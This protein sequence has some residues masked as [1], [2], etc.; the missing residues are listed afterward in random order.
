MGIKWK[1]IMD[2]ECCDRCP[3]SQ[4]AY[5]QAVG[6]VMVDYQLNRLVA[7]LT[8]KPTSMNGLMNIIQPY[9]VMTKQKMNAYEEKK[10]KKRKQKRR[11]KQGVKC[12]SIAET[13]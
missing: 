2:D 6:V 5:A 10:R 3:L 9:I 1:E 8:T 7:V 13:K 11:L 4:D 12:V